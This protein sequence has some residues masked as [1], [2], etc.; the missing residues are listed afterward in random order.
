MTLITDIH[1]TLIGGSSKESLNHTVEKYLQDNN[2]SQSV[3]EWKQQNYS[4]L[5]RWAYPP[6]EDYLDADIKIRSGDT[7]LVQEGQAQMALYVQKCLDVKS[8]IEKELQ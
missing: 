2:M 6:I 8:R 3:T 7:E 4:L 5:R 1:K